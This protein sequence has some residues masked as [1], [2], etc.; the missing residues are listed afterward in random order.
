M[1]SDE[2]SAALMVAF[3]TK[4]AGSALAKKKPFSPSASLANDHSDGDDDAMRANILPR[5]QRALCVRVPVA[6]INTAD[7]TYYEPV[8]EVETIVREFAGKGRNMMYQV[9]LFGGR[10]K[11]VSDGTQAT[12][13][14][15][16]F[17]GKG[18]GRNG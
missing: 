18:G 6:K 16:S 9:R 12:E 17:S 7:Y 2:D 3:R 1:S 13:G 15:L 8:D 14:H 5:K 4:G 11:Q 10:I